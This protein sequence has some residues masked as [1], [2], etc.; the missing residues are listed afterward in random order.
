MS[1]QFWDATIVL[2][3]YKTERL[4]P[5]PIVVHMGTNGAF[6]DA[7]FDQMMAVVG[8]KRQVFFVN[9]REPRPWETEVNQRLAT[10][11]KKYPNAHL[12]DWHD[13]GG[14]HDDWFV[15]D[16]IHLTGAGAQ[17]YADFIHRHLQ[18]GY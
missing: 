18:A 14:P 1:R 2:Q 3:A 17:G 6:S 8:S 11:V 7:Q 16:G 9:A 10:D 15:K 5:P 12:L 13:W 4:L